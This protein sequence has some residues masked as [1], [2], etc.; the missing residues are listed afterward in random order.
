MAG[1]FDARE[2][3]QFGETLADFVIG[4]I[5]PEAVD[6]SEAFVLKRQEA[7]HKMLLQVEVFK[8]EH[9][10]NLFKKAKFGNA[11]KWK[12][13]D[14]GYTAEFADHLTRSLLLRA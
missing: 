7:M 8:V 13:L 6:D 14:A 9:K 4:R 5:P 1:W 11:F 10:L 3:Q 12:L 2:A